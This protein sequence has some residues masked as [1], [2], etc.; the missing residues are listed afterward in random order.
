MITC[1][2][3]SHPPQSPVAQGE[4]DHCMSSATPGEGADLMDTTEPHVNQQEFRR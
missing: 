2:K 1:L 4:H 3:D